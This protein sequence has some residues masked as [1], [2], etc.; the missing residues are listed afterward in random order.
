MVRVRQK[1]REIGSELPCAVCVICF[2]IN[3]TEFGHVRERNSHQE[4]NT[5][6]RT[7][8]KCATVDDDF[9]K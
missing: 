8:P 1:K 4:E 3:L 9:T 6:G 5:R 2:D 7:M